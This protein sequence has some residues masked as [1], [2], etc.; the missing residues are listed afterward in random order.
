[1]QHLLAVSYYD[2][3]P[4]PPGIKPH[5]PSQRSGTILAKHVQCACENCGDRDQQQEQQQQQQQQQQQRQQ[6]NHNQKQLTNS[7]IN[8]F[9]HDKK[10]KVNMAPSH[11]SPSKFG[12]LLYQRRHVFTP[13]S[14]TK[15]PRRQ[16][17]ESR[18]GWPPH[19]V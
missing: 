6:H 18:R 12:F 19:K 16:Q 10:I 7:H 13:T 14:D 3:L 9:H 4:I 5:H 11:G 15:N 8:M 2:I 1:M 17:K